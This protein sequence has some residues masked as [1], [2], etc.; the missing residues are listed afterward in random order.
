MSFKIQVSR[1]D[2]LYHYSLIRKNNIVQGNNRTT[3]ELIEYNNGP[4]LV[5]DIIHIKLT[6]AANPYSKN[7]LI[8]FL[9]NSRWQPTYLAEINS[10]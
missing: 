7:D 2:F 4:G 5:G 1:H 10:Q 9:N 8:I 3:N 6:I